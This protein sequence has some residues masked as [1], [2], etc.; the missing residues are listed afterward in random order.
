MITII[1]DLEARDKRIHQRLNHLEWMVSQS[2]LLKSTD[3]TELFR[4]AEGINTLLRIPRF[5]WRRIYLLRL[6][7]AR[8]RGRV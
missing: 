8:A 4:A 2:N 1:A 3:N 6:L 5:F 7:I